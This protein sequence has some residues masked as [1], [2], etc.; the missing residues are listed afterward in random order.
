MLVG[1]SFSALIAQYC[2][3]VVSVLLCPVLSR[4]A[5]NMMT[6]II[7]KGRKYIHSDQQPPNLCSVVYHSQ[8]LMLKKSP[9]GQYECGV[10]RNKDATFT[11]TPDTESYRSNF[12][13][14]RGFGRREMISGCSTH[15]SFAGT[16]GKSMISSTFQSGDSSVR[17]F[18][19]ANA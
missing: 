6:R 3:E 13:H 16:W 15:Q 7:T 9:P 11:I 12:S 8:R 1:A 18:F 14:Y 10:K 2:V 17:L 4:I 5:G 19:Q